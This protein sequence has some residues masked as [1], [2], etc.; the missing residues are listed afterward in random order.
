MAKGAEGGDEEEGGDSDA[1]EM[2]ADE[3]EDLEEGAWD[4][5]EEISE[6]EEGSD[7]EDDEAEESSEDEIPRPP[8]KK[9]K[10][11]ANH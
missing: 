1:E 2:S 11:R 10:A 8:P 3:E 5:E 9:L 7:D 6:G 4:E